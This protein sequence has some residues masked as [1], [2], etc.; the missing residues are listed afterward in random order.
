MRFAN[1]ASFLPPWNTHD[2]RTVALFE[3]CTGTK[4]KKLMPNAPCRD[5][6]Q[7]KKTATIT[8]DGSRFFQLE[9]DSI[10]PQL[11]TTFPALSALRRLDTIKPAATT[12]MLSRP[13]AMISMR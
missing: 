2:K 6:K 8:S 11:S 3:R 10:N 1:K 4:S 9:A 13:V 5:D 7:S 12:R